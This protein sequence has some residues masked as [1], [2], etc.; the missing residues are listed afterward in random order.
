[1]FTWSFVA[2]NYKTPTPIRG[3]LLD[4]IPAQLH[5]S[6]LVQRHIVDGLLLA[7]RVVASF[8]QLVKTRTT[9]L[10]HQPVQ[11]KTIKQTPIRS[12]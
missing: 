11:H 6:L 12:E 3:Q 7:G 2:V 5:T 10:Q 4:P 9:L 1:M 8:L